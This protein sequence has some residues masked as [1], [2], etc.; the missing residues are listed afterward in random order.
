MGQ[1]WGHRS[2]QASSEG[3]WQSTQLVLRHLMASAI[4]QCFSETHVGAWVTLP[5]LKCGAGCAL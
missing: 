2:T 4:H 1:S 5:A 3:W